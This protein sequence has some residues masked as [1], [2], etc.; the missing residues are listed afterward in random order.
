MS[1]D[2]KCFLFCGLSYLLLLVAPAVTLAQEVAEQ[3]AEDVQVESE[4]QVAE[5]EQLPPKTSEIFDRHFIQAF[6]AMSANDYEKGV[7]QIGVLAEKAFEKS[8]LN[9]PDY[10]FRLIEESRALIEAGEIDKGK[11]VL[12]KAEDL[13]PHDARVH[14]SMVE[15]YKTIG[16]SEAFRHLF[17]GAS[18]LLLLPQSSI[19]L[20]LNI[21]LVFLVSATSSL[22]I[23][24]LVQL[25]LNAKLIA[26]QCSQMLP[27]LY[28]GIGGP[29]FYLLIFTLPIYGG[30]LMV[31]AVWS[32]VLSS[33]LRSSKWLGLCAG[34]VISLWWLVTP[35][36]LNV[37]KQ[38]A[39][40]I[41]SSLNNIKAQSYGR[42]D[43]ER[44]DT[45]LQLY[46]RDAM[47]LFSKGLQ[48][49]Y[50]GNLDE[51]EK[52]FLKL[53]ALPGTG[54]KRLVEVPS[55]INLGVISYKRKDYQKAKE[56]LQEAEVKDTP[57]ASLLLNLSNVHLALID[58]VGHQKYYKQ[59]ISKDPDIIE[60]YK[61][62]AFS[63]PDFDQLMVAQAPSWKVYYKRYLSPYLIVD[64]SFLDDRHK[65]IKKVYK[66]LVK[67]GTRRTLVTLT[68]LTLV[69]GLYGA[70][71]PKKRYY[72]KYEQ[73]RKP[74][75]GWALLPGG[76]F[77]AGEMAE[78]GWLLLSTIFTLAL[79]ALGVGEQM[80]QVLPFSFPVYEVSL[81]VL[82]VIYALNIV[83][84]VIYY[85][86]MVVNREAV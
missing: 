42:E 61:Q 23:V 76:L 29:V 21:F 44:I 48:Y 8:Y 65:R 11:F 68:L 82:G 69:F 41:Q 40:P 81:V 80:Y 75:L 2:I 54:V 28:R 19:P 45:W 14:L 5:V 56:Y 7:E 22:L 55:L 20:L 67:D 4:P 79:F 78:I 3:Q 25:I 49:L 43:A 83:V 52:V 62:G 17:K 12:R 53:R 32:I 26:R 33:Y 31:V 6:A 59:A 1:K 60:K 57:T 77:M 15:L 64:S 46:P 85:D 74:S 10:S 38:T 72:V 86:F 16:L 27:T 35:I 58:T 37:A 70:F 63:Y 66:Y 50:E 39:N 36:A 24:C 71:W 84:S 34:A 9:L 30:I 13:S 47:L 18:L 73:Q 51:S